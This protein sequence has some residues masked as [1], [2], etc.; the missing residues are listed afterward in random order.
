MNT[1]WQDGLAFYAALS[2]DSRS[3]IANESGLDMVIWDHPD[4]VI[5]QI[6][7]LLRR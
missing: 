6:L 7:D 1:Y 4:L 2:T 3:V 5:E